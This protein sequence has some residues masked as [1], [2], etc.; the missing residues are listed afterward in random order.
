MWFIKM[1]MHLTHIILSKM[2][3][4]LGIVDL[5]FSIPIQV[6]TSVACLRK[7]LQLQLAYILYNFNSQNKY[8]IT[9]WCFKLCKL[10][11]QNRGIINTYIS[12]QIFFFMFE[13]IQTEQQTKGHTG[14]KL[15]LISYKRA[16]MLLKMMSHKLIFNNFLSLT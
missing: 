1:H 14:Q 13:H 3:P 12:Q 15:K 10:Q 11:L 5:C 9:S 8:L 4:S 2:F 7:I 6:E 16:V